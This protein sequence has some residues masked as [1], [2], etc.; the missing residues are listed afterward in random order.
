MGTVLYQFFNSFHKV[1]TINQRMV[2]NIK[3][4]EEYTYKYIIWSMGKTIKQNKDFIILLLFCVIYNIITIGL[5]IGMNQAQS[6]SIEFIIIYFPLFWVISGL[7]LLLIIKLM[8]I[9]INNWIRWVILFLS[10]P[11][12][13]LFFA[14]LY[15]IIT[16]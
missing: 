6:E 11:V 10:T 16:R 7:I 13:V 15:Y 5:I 1:A 8:R 12:S 2:F 4:M 14:Y 9:S 3:K